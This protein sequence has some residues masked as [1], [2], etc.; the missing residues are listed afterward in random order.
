[1]MTGGMKTSSTKETLPARR[2]VSYAGPLH[3]PS[4]LQAAIDS[5]RSVSEQGSHLERIFGERAQQPAARPGGVIQ[6]I[7]EEEFDDTFSESNMIFMSSGLEVSEEVKNTILEQTNVWESQGKNDYEKGWRREHARK[8]IYNHLFHKRKTQAKEI[9]LDVAYWKSVLSG[10]FQN[11]EELLHPDISLVTDQ[12]KK[13]K[14]VKGVAPIKHR[15]FV[16][17]T[18]GQGASGDLKKFIFHSAQFSS[19]SPIAMYNE[20]DNTGGLFHY[21]AQNKDQQ[22]KLLEMYEKI[23][24]EYIAM[25]P[26]TATDFEQVQK[27]FQKTD[28]QK[29]KA[30]STSHSLLLTDN[31][32]LAFVMG[33]VDKYAAYLNLTGMTQLPEPVAKE[34]PLTMYHEPKA[35]EESFEVFPGPWMEPSS[36]PSTPGGDGAR[37]VWAGVTQGIH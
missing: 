33:S 31:G 20:E 3:A 9:C 30:G 7:T 12:Y 2:P 25:A 37:T 1:M 17:V 10:V 19:C 8:S 4:P 34:T 36:A 21:A 24:P 26:N 18:M 35:Y 5:S 15:I 23:R 27:L 6:M 13:L 29:V 22:A 28:V 32:E 16:E 14:D 11:G